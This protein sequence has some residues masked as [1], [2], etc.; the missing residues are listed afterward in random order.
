MKYTY[1]VKYNGKIVDEFDVESFDEFDAYSSA[2][3][4]AAIRLKVKEVDNRC[5]ECGEPAYRE[6]D[7]ITLCKEHWDAECQNA[8]GQL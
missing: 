5:K 8:Q 1:I 4:E 7:G 2:L 6:L 3:S